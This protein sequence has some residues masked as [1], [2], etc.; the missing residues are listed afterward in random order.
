MGVKMSTESIIISIC[1]ILAIIAG[2]IL[3]IQIS[4]YLSHKKI[5][6]ERKLEIFKVLMA[7]R[8]A[9]LTPAHTQ[10]LNMI[11]VEFRQKVKLERDVISAWKLYHAHLQDQ[12]YP[13]ETWGSRKGDLLIDLLYAMAISLDYDFDKSQ[14][15]SLSYY[16]SGYGELEDDQYTLRKKAVELFKGKISIPIHIVNKTEPNKTNS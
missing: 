9:S 1:T 12:N 10:A 6:K 7:T 13:K 4:Q 16:P 2:P 15:K 5:L 8:S 14:I 3:S 11:D